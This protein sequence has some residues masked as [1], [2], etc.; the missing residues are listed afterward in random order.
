MGFSA[1]IR[2]ARGI[3]KAALGRLDVLDVSD[4][5][6]SRVGVKYRC[7]SPSAMARLERLGLGLATSSS[8]S[9][10]ATG[11][12]AERSS[13][14][15]VGPASTCSALVPRPPTSGSARSWHRSRPP[16]QKQ[17]ALLAAGD[18]QCP[19]GA[20]AASAQVGDHSG[21]SASQRTGSTAKVPAPFPGGAPRDVAKDDA[22]ASGGRWG[23]DSRGGSSMAIKLMAGAPSLALRR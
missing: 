5:C 20:V 4:D 13:E 14:D 17:S 18:Q 2:A 11:A 9:H 6:W 22:E 12:G 23:D 21:G 16:A 3:A 15:V 7:V 19:A 8:P 1:G 10:T